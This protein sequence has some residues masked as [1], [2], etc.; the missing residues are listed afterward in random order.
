MQAHQYYHM[1]FRQRFA[2]TPHLPV[3]ISSLATPRGDPSASRR[4]GLAARSHGPP[5]VKTINGYR[6]TGD[7]FPPLE[8]LDPRVQTPYLNNPTFDVPVTQS[9][10][11]LS[12][13]HSTGLLIGNSAPVDAA[14]P[15]TAPATPSAITSSFKTVVVRAAATEDS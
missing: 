8:P 1:V 12:L 9:D 15:P 14:I 13:L 11:L 10:G 3:A 4:D 5:S 2:R 7:P 6:E